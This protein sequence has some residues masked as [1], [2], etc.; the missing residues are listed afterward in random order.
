MNGTFA[1]RPQEQH[2]QLTSKFLSFENF[3]TFSLNKG[4]IFTPN[5]IQ[6]WPGKQPQQKPFFS[7]Y[8]EF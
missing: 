6:P 8:A 2:C 4:D 1:V 5:E 7:F 3:L